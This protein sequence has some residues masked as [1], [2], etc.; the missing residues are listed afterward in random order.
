MSLKKNCH[1]HTSRM[2]EPTAG[3]GDQNRDG[4]TLRMINPSENFFVQ[5][6]QTPKKASDENVKPNQVFMPPYKVPPRPTT[7]NKRPQQQTSIPPPIPTPISATKPI[8]SPIETT[9]QVKPPRVVT[10][11]EPKAEPETE[12]YYDQDTE[13]DSS[14]NELLNLNAISTCP[15]CV[16]LLQDYQKYTP[17]FT[18]QDSRDY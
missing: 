11:V 5:Q 2:T 4:S 7:T 3:D 6:I 18:S 17:A 1:P 14:M 9:P 10:I 16:A 13:Y 12:E 8:S 15:C